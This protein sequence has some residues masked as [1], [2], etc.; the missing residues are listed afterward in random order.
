MFLRWVH[1]QKRDDF[2]SFSAERITKTILIIFSRDKLLML[3]RVN[4]PLSLINSIS[5]LK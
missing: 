4:K 5:E 1:H 3:I 2:S